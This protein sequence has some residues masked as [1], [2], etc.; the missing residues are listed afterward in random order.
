M[1]LALYK[2][3]WITTNATAHHHAIFR[4]KWDIHYIVTRTYTSRQAK[5]D[6]KRI[7]SLFVRLE[8]K[9]QRY[10]Y[11]CLHDRLSKGFAKAHPGRQGLLLP[12]SGF[13]VNMIHGNLWARVSFAR[14]RQTWLQ[15]GWHG[16]HMHNHSLMCIPELQMKRLESQW[17]RKKL[18]VNPASKSILDMSI[19]WINTNSVKYISSVYILK[20]LEGIFIIYI[21]I[22]IY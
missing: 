19:T 17:C 11:A 20:D 14:A 21:Y 8:W 4:H 2:F 18:H 16:H 7:S 6:E 13:A 15:C 22:Y 9:S 1:Q 5:N 3:C 10:D 12:G